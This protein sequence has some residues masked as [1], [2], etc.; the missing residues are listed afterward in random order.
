MRFG[1]TLTEAEVRYLADAGMGANRR[2]RRLAPL[3]ARAAHDAGQVRELD[4]WM[5]ANVS[6][7]GARRRGSRA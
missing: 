5:K 1:D 2:G 4:R 7:V 3:E 6:P